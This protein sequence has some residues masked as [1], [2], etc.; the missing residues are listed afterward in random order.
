MKWGQP[1]SKYSLI[2]RVPADSQA[3]VYRVTSCG[4]DVRLQAVWDER[5]PFPTGRMCQRCNEI[6][7]KEWQAAEDRR[8]LD[9]EVSDEFLHK[10]LDAVTDRLERFL[11]T[12]D[13]Y[14]TDEQPITDTMEDV[15]HVKW[16]LHNRI[17]AQDRFAKHIA[18]F[19]HEDAA[20][21]VL[22]DS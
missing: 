6:H 12:C 4:R 5:P 3:G 20:N 13:S 9:L 7:R 19:V 18:R 16:H 22:E 1:K 17:E 10:V 21:K 8:S 2:H 11:L 14:Y 15:L